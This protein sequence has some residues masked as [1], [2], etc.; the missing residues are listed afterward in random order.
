MP[1]ALAT[2]VASCGEANKQGGAPPPPVVT[3]AK[4]VK[5]TVADFDEYVGRFTAINSVEM[6]ARVSGYLD[7][8]HFKDGQIVKQGDLLFT[9]D[10]RPFQNTLDQLIPIALRGVGFRPAPAS[11]LLQRNLLIYGLGGIIAPFLGIKAIDVVVTALH[12]A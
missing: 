7:G 2:L 4:P 12:L 10:K 9:I 6:R 3:V 8:V 1:C 5:R 11:V